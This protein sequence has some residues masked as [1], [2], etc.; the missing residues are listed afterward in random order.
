MR[1]VR[2]GVATLVVRMDHEVQAHELVEIG[3]VIAEHS[4][5]AG[6]VV[7]LARGVLVHHAVLEGA[8]VDDGGDLGH[9][10]DHV[11]DVLQGVLPVGGLVHALCVGGGELGLGLAGQDADAQLCHG[12]HVLW[13]RAQQGLHVRGQ[14]GARR[15]LGGEAAGLLESGDLRGEQ[16]PHQRL[17]QG[18]TLASGAL[19]G[20]QLGLQLGDG[21]ASESDALLRVQQ[22]GLVV[23]ALHVAAASDA[24]IDCH[25]TEG[26]VA[27][28]GL[29]LLHRRLLGRDLV[30]KNLLEA[31]R[32]HVPLGGIGRQAQSRESSVHGGDPK[33]D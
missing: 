17:G 7:E 14:L 1:G 2:R 15:E 13:Q 32:R 29:E 4:V 8:A 5:E 11:Q 16:Q 24:L 23:H 12:V 30:S 27:V 10:G 19:E 26:H 25:L 33:G 20:G 22:R 6:G 28:I 31:L 21:V 3:R 9:L 18:L